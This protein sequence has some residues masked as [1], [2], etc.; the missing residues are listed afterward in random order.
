MLDGKIIKEDL[1]SD[2]ALYALDE[3]SKK[4]KEIIELKSIAF[5]N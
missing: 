5:N 3:I 2:D 1:V 4:L